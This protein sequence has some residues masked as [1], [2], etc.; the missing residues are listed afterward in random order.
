MSKSARDVFAYGGT[1]LLQPLGT[2]TEDVMLA[3]G[4]THCRADCMVVK[5]S[6]RKPL[7]R[8]TA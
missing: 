3:E 1:T 4:N 2:F 6:G 7:G 5:G 8:E